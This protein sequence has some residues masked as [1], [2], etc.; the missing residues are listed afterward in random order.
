[1]K[2]ASGCGGGEASKKTGKEP[3]GSG[4]KTTDTSSKVV[5][6]ARVA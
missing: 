3:V 4:H 6:K 1:M 5:K 2:L